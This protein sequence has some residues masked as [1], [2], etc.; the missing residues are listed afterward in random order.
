[1]KTRLPLLVAV[2]ALIAGFA[3]AKEKPV[4]EKGMPAAQIVQLVG[5]PDEISPLKGN[6]GQAETWIYRR[7][8]G[9]T[10]HQTA[11]TETSLPAMTGFTANGP[12]I[13]R[14]IV[15]DYR[16]KYVRAYQVTAL[17]MVDGRL[18]LGRQWFTRDEQFAD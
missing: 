2:F 15:P 18:Q 5:E 12:T 11:N 6:E 9:Q 10:V 7:K 4:L 13:G 1:M 16:L 17:L 14:V 3:S 8:I